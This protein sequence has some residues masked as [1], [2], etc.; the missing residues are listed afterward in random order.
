MD[1][2]DKVQRAHSD[3]TKTMDSVDNKVD[4]VHCLPGKCPWTP[5]IMSMD[6]VESLDKVHGY[7]EQSPGSL[8]RLDNV[9]GLSGH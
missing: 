4:V 7:S 3:W 8:L 6:L 1:T 2:L 5:W 9:H